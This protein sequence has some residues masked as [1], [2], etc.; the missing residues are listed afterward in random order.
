M[1]RRIAN[2]PSGMLTAFTAVPSN[3]AVAAE[4]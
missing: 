1:S 3:D 2:E 4:P